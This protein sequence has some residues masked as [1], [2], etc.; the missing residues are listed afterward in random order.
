M[1]MKKLMTDGETSHRDSEFN[2]HRLLSLS[3][4]MMNIF[5]IDDEVS[6]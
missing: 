5:I 3:S 6:H 4:S 2:H 1:V